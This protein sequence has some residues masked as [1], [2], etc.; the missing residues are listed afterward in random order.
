LQT[1]VTKRFKLYHLSSNTNGFCY[2]N[3]ALAICLIFPMALVL[4]RV[5][6]TWSN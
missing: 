3:L 4:S 1:V 2:Q 5:K 6:A